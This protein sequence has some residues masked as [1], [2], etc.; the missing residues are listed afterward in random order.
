M[1]VHISPAHYLELDRA[2]EYRSEYF[3]GQMIEVVG[4]G[5]VHS[6]VLGNTGCALHAQLRTRP[7]VVLMCNMRTRVGPTEQYAYPDVVVVCDKPEVLDP[8]EDVLL[9]PT[10]IIEVLS[11]ASADFDRDFKFVAYT[12]IPS[13]KEYVLVATD[14]ASIEVFTRQPDGLWS[15]AKATRL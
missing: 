13:L 5:L 7:C 10:V 8:R 15:Q 6:E 9:N 1:S 14:G 3:D 4:G 2:A 12:A 11:P